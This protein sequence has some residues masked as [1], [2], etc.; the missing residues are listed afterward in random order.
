M[1]TG[2]KLILRS[3]LTTNLCQTPRLNP[4][5]YLFF[6]TSRCTVIWIKVG[7]YVF[8]ELVR[9]WFCRFSCDFLFFVFLLLRIW[10]CRLH[11]CVAFFCWRRFWAVCRAFILCD[12]LITKPFVIILFWYIKI[13]TNCAKTWIVFENHLKQKVLEFVFCIFVI[14]L[15]GVPKDEIMAQ[16]KADDDSGPGAE[17]Q[18]Q[19]D[20]DEVCSFETHTHTHTHWNCNRMVESV[21]MFFGM[22]LSLWF[23][24]CR[25]DKTLFLTMVSVILLFF[26]SRSLIDAPFMEVQACVLWSIYD[27]LSH[28]SFTKFCNNLF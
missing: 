19:K 10:L 5:R 16:A 13:I 4:K 1:F 27:D 20:W 12:C 7:F 24:I 6:F 22:V 15:C 28:R 9:F 18:R 17:K 3:S 11:I 23:C 14:Y 26:S 2:G 8:F 21:W 25:K